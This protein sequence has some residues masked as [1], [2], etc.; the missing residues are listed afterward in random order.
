[1]AHS[2]RKKLKEERGGKTKNQ[3]EKE[4]RQAAMKNPAKDPQKRIKELEE[5]AK[6]VKK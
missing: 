6:T 5:W 1:M 4:K 2:N 3:L